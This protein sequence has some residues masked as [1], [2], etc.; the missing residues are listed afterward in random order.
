[1]SVIKELI[2]IAAPEA[3][4]KVVDQAIKATDVAISAV[5]KVEH[6]STK[7]DRKIEQKVESGRRR[8]IK[9]E[10]NRLCFGD[11][12]TE[13]I[14]FSVLEQSELAWGLTK[15]IEKQVVTFSFFNENEQLLYTVNSKKYRKQNLTIFDA[16]GKPLGKTE[17]KG[18]KRQPCISVYEEGVYRGDFELT[19]KGDKS[20]TYMMGD[21]RVNYVH[22]RFV[23]TNA[24]GSLIANE[25]RHNLH[26]CIVFNEGDDALFIAI[27]FVCANAIQ[28]SHGEVLKWA[29]G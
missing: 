28:Y 29:R 25:S 2:E 20:S 26:R 6:A 1:M 16:N 12:G 19:P 18:T 27:L 14:F 17:V 11:D 8:F 21:L 4:D 24:S 9:K 23:I 7:A 13:S 3:L 15:N 22:G 10:A 5:E